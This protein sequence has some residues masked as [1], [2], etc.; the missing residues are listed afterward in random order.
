MKHI[1]YTRVISKSLPNLHVAMLDGREVGFF[2]KPQDA[3]G[4]RN[5]WRSYVG[6]GEEAKFLYHTWNKQDAMRA[7]T[8][9][10]R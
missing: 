6:I 3:A 2:Y 10:I 8:V 4:D 9:A 1:Y 7:V 5:A